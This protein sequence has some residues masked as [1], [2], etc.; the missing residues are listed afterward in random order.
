MWVW[1]HQNGQKAAQGYYVD[2]DPTNTWAFWKPDGQ[3]TRKSDIS[4][5]T[6]QIEN[7][8]DENEEIEINTGLDDLQHLAISADGHKIALCGIV[9][10][11][12]WVGDLVIN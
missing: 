5:L 6:K 11:R 3:L 4:E 9:P 10:G 12:L 1:W 8:N 7:H 2:G